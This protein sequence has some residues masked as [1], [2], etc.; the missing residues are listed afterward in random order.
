MAFQVTMMLADAAQALDN[1]LYILGGG[2]SITGPDPTS[3]AIAL[4]I[5]VPWDEANRRHRMRLELLDPDGHAVTVDSPVGKQSLVIENEFEVGRPPGVKP[6]T[7]IEISL[8]LN[9]GPLPLEAG[10]RYEWRLLI[11]GEASDAWTLPFSTRERPLLQ[12]PQD[13]A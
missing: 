9:L 2:W 12:Q 7:P 11:D 1:K 5:R 10:S 8:A 6:G 4:Q 13:P 3:S